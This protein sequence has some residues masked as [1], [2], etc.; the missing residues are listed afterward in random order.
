MKELNQKEMEQVAGAGWK[1]LVEGVV[2]LFEQIGEGVVGI[3]EDAG[4]VSK[5]TGEHI[6]GSL[7]KGEKAIDGFIDSI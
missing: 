2:H 1:E 3:L 4:V 7:E 6:K 5:E